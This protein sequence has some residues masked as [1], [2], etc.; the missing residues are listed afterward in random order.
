[1]PNTVVESGPNGTWVRYP[2]FTKTQINWSNNTNITVTFYYCEF[3]NVKDE[4]SHKCWDGG[5]VP[6]ADP[7]NNGMPSLDC[8]CDDPRKAPKLVGNPINPANG[9]KIQLEFDY[10]VGG[11]PS[12]LALARFYNSKPVDA[13]NRAHLFGPLWTTAYDATLTFEPARQVLRCARRSY[14]K[15]VFCSYTTLAVPGAAVTRSD[16]KIYRLSL[17]DNGWVADADVND[18]LT[19]QYA[20]DGQTIIGWSYIS[21]SSDSIE[22][23]DAQGRLIQIK[24]RSGAVQFLTYSD[25]ATNDTSIAKSP[26]EAPVCSNVQPGTALPPVSS[27][28]SRTIGGDNSILSM[29]R[30]D[31]K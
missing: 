17:G 25:G 28:V 6:Q 23:F 12:K 24:S 9:N 3:P 2:S 14:D 19:A 20:A 26:E 21:A 22:Q 1:M 31:S 29:I 8:D 18:R 16:N 5:I 10:E 7:K 27:C 4:G 13:A 15:K 30:S 11:S